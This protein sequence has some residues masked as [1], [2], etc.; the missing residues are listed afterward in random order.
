MASPDAVVF[1]CWTLSNNLQNGGGIYE[2]ISFN[3]VKNRA[4]GN[5]ADA[6]DFGDFAGLRICWRDYEH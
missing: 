4:S 2:K 1:F 5:C 6:F 3:Q